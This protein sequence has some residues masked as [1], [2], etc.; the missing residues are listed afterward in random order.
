MTSTSKLFV[1]PRRPRQA[2]GDGSQGV[3]V[4]QIVA[5]PSIKSRIRCRRLHRDD[6]YAIALTGL[7]IIPILAFTG[8]AVD[9]GAWYARAAQIQR[10][11][12]A[13]ALAGARY[14][15][16]FSRA[17]QEARAVAT[18]NGFT[19]GVNG[20]TVAVS[21]IPGNS[22]R[23]R[24]T[25][26]DPA[27][28]QYFS[29]LFRSSVEIERLA[30]GELIRPIPMGS[31]RNFL[32]TNQLN[33]SFGSQFVENFWLSVSGYC[34]RREHG[35][36]L[37]PRTDANGGSGSNSSDSANQGY[38]RGCVPGAASTPSGNV[39][40]NPEYTDQGYFYAVE[41]LSGLSS[42]WTLQMYDGP[43]CQYEKT[44]SQ[45][46]NDSGAGN[47]QN[48]GTN[49][50]WRGAWS[51][52]TQYN[53][54]DVVRYNGRS[55][56]ARNTNTGVTPPSVSAQSNGSWSL[57][58]R[59]LY[60]VIIRDKD[61]PD[62]PSQAT[63][64]YS[65]VLDPSTMCKLSNGSDDWRMR[66]KNVYTFSAAQLAAPSRYFVQVRPLQ[67]ETNLQEGQN[68]FSFRLARN[69]SFSP[70][71]DDPTISGYSS[72][73]LRLYALSHLG[74][75]AN[76]GGSN[77]TFYLAE[78]SPEY[79]NHTL[80]V[81][82]WDP[83][84]GAIAIRLLNPL[85]Q[86]V[87]FTWE[88]ACQDGSYQSETGSSCSGENAPQGGYGP[89]SPDYSGNGKDVSGNVATSL[90]P[91][92]G[93][94]GQIGKYSGRMLRLKYQLPADMSAAYGG[95]RWWKIQ[96][97]VGSRVGDRTTWSVLVKGDP[98]RLVPNT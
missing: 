26:T 95:Y 83:A 47:R 97:V 49:P 4:A 72:D 68:Q 84:E 9:L 21:Q 58:A 8:F 56:I 39:V 87:A 36:R 37:T 17:E 51:A 66:W 63:V 92:G 89:G 55:W 54:G 98:V 91:W 30:T 34:A 79:N 5:R 61:R 43:H 48:V 93:R 45:S 86:A 88:I 38:F 2:S 27:V 80:E 53:Q 50:N 90:R 20:V 11:A 70:C 42:S 28:S 74:V 7:L 57:V 13:A 1:R 59:R 44:N 77:P 25:I 94:N 23:I 31:P 46:S 62:D 69:G 19:N 85:D 16:N 3:R 10:A 29:K 73:C 12:E 40:A 81:E 15:P 65:I 67:S 75:Y 32:G 22:S 71:S 96:Y 76:A 35:D 33:S 14:M 82:L 78:I 60:E 18:K 6:G 41:T 24:V 52:S 64:L